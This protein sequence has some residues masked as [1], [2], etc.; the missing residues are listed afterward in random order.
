M[1]STSLSELLAV[2]LVPLVKS[3]N[4]QFLLASSKRKA[5]WG[6]TEKIKKIKTVEGARRGE[7]LRDEGQKKT[8]TLHHFQAYFFLGA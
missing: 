1:S 8:Q 6:E 3:R 5:E 2:L 7:D 4:R